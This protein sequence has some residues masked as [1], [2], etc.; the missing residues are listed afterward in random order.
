MLNQSEHHVTF[1]KTCTQ[2]A[3]SSAGLP[4]V[5]DFLSYAPVQ[6]IGA[7][8]GASARL[9]RWGASPRGVAYQGLGVPAGEVRGSGGR[10]GRIVGGCRRSYFGDVANLTLRTTPG[11]AR[12]VDAGDHGTKVK[13]AMASC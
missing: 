2:S 5:A 12:R 13:S 4:Q 9:R 8:K 3:V 7:V 6:S 1:V 11:V 10:A